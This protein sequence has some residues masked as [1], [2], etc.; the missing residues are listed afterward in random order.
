MGN[1][2]KIQTKLDK[3]K[4]KTNLS[5]LRFHL[6]SRPLQAKD[7]FTR[8][9]STLRH[10]PPSPSS[11][12]SRSSR[13][14]K[15]LESSRSPEE[16]VRFQMRDFHVPE[17]EDQTLSMSIPQRSEMLLMSEWIPPSRREP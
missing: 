13:R 6:R 11:L 14:L 7:K 1:Q 10:P 8:G 4:D 2:F 5:L 3:C 16:L 15:S 17:R 12:S 9:S